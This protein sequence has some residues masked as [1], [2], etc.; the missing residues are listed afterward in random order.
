MPYIV[1]WE[2]KRKMIFEGSVI[3]GPFSYKNQPKMKKSYILKTKIIKGA[4]SN[5]ILISESI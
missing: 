4:E 3:A 1:E 5:D 2:K